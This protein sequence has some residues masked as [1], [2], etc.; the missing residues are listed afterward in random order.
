MAIR[1][2][3]ASLIAETRL[4]IDDSDASCQTFSDQQIQNELDKTRDPVRYEELT[5]APSV[6]NASESDAGPA[7]YVWADYYSEFHW[8]EPDVVI[9]DGHFVVLTPAASDLLTGHWQFQLTPFVNGTPPGQY[10]PL[11]ATGNTYD[12]YAA[13]ANLLEMWAAKAARAYDFTADGASFRRSQM[14][15]GLRTQ[16]DYYRKQARVHTV[17]AVRD[18]IETTS[19]TESVPLLGNN[20]LLI[21]DE[22]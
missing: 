3:M 19:H 9:Q 16:A 21:R 14:A 17:Y 12:L 18:D 8:W 13:A 20:R 5:P 2:T 15:Q 22:H 11:F 7:Q 10:P 4:L 6:V 1:T